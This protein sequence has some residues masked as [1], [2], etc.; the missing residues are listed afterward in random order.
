MKT[1]IYRWIIILLVILIGVMI[2]MP[3]LEVAG[4][5][6]MLKLEGQ[7]STADRVKQYGDTVHRRL[8][9]DFQ[10]ADVPYPPKRLVLVGLKK[11]MRLEVYA[12][13]EEDRLRFIRSYLILDASGRNGPKLRQGDMQVPEGIYEVESLNPNS[14]YHLSLKVSYPNDF[15][16]R[17]AA[18]DGER[19]SAAIS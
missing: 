7:A 10:K 8:M 3:Y 2:F 15:D 1:I 9:P 4:R 5:M 17:K 16:R 19:N 18:A 14:R 12:A 11:E 13:D 6:I